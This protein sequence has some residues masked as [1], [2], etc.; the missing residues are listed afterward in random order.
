M[1]VK[2][3]ENSIIKEYEIEKYIDVSVPLIST[4]II[5]KN[6]KKINKLYEYLKI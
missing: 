4:I 1:K 5:S 3:Q 6:D 2:F